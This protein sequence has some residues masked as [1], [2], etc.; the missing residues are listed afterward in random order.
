[1]VNVSNKL[2]LLLFADDSNAFVSGKDIDPIIDIIN[3]AL[4]DLVVWLNTNKLTLNIKKTHFMIFSPPK[5]LINNINPI[6]INNQNIDRVEST[7]FLGVLLDDKLGFGA[8]ITHVRKKVAKGIYILGRAKKFFD[9]ITI[10]DLYYAFIHPYFNYCIDVWGSTYSTYIDP[11]VKLQKRAVRII[12]G[13]P[14][15][16]HTLDLFRRFNIVQIDKYKL[17]HYSIYIFLYKLINHLHPPSIHSHFILNS[18]IHNHATRRAGLIHVN[19]YNCDARKR[20]L[21]HQSSILPKSTSE[22]DYNVPI[23]SFK[24]QVKTHLLFLTD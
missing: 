11:L 6:I 18:D 12:A 19:H 7:R 23:S 17:Y 24:F 20:A 10:K 4:E 13:A 1:M 3:E 2:F 5:K 8:H 15:K 14:F 21:R 16:A 22:V 9:E